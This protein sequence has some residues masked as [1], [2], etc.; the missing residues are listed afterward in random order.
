MIESENNMLL[1][2]P[3]IVDLTKRERNEESKIECCQLKTVIGRSG[4]EGT[5]DAPLRPKAHR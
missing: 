1:K 2:R 4:C 5:R 3:S